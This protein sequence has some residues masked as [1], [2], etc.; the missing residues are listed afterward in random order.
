MITIYS[1]K[2]IL[3]SIALSYPITR[4]I[5]T[6]PDKI[7]NDSYCNKSDSINKDGIELVVM[8]KSLKGS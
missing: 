1:M 8:K 3:A 7:L 4:G 6:V 5:T 2:F